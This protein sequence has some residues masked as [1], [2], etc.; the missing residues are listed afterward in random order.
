MA[1]S[2][3]LWAIAL[4]T[5]LAGV[6]A[7][8]ADVVVSS[9]LDTEATLLGTM[10]KLAL[11]ANGIK[12]K[13]RLT[14]GG[15]PVVRKAITSGEIDIYPEY[16]GNGAFFFNKADDP[17]WKDHKKGYE[18]ARTL[19]YEANKIVWLAPAPANNTWAIA[20][21]K[22][23]ADKAKLKTMSDFGKWVGGGD[24]V[25]LACSAEF[26]NSPAALPSFQKT[27]G[28]A[29]KPVQLIVL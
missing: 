20:V 21:R 29:M 17:V 16:T 22:D 6:P 4:A 9:K 7:A 24:K 8:R 11:E 27:Y 26:V 25:V 28:F 13:D 5:L 15:T 1:R 3:I 14:L 19:D 18:S 23:I 10:I 12:T 2:K